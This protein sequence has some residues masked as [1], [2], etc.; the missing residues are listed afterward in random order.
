MNEVVS[1]WNWIFSFQCWSNHPFTTSMQKGSTKN[2]KAY[3]VDI[4][5]RTRMC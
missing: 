4:D 5:R 2:W 1:G 3:K